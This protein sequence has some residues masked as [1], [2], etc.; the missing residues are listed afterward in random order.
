MFHRRLG[1]S[2][3]HFLIVLIPRFLVFVLVFICW[4]LASCYCA[5]VSAFV[6]V[7]V[8]SSSRLFKFSVSS[9]LRPSVGARLRQTMIVV[10]NWFFDGSLYTSNRSI[11]PVQGRSRYS[12]RQRSRS[13][14][15]LS[16]NWERGKESS[17]SYSWGEKIFCNLLFLH[18]TIRLNYGEMIHMDLGGRVKIAPTHIC[19]PSTAKQRAHFRDYLG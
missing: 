19:I 6:P 18:I 14:D 4:F 16:F 17:F 12:R 1:I 13:M 9:S 2:R 3:F 11:L 8:S 10:M 15:V 5:L 7:L